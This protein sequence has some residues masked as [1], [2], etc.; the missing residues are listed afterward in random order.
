MTTQL[1]EKT[2]A[3]VKATAPI[4]A[5][6]GEAITRA[7]Y[8]RLFQ[9]QAIA[10]LFNNA[11][12]ASGAQQKALAGAIVAYAQ[13]ID[14]LGVLGAAVER[15]AQK[16]VAYN[17]LPQ[18]YDAV[19]TAL[20]GALVEV[21]GEAANEDILTAWGEAYWFLADILKGREAAIREAAAVSDGGWVGW[22]LFVV[23]KK[24]R[25]SEVISS[26]V[27]RPRDGGPVVSHRPGQYLTFQFDTP[28]Q[29]GLKR[30]YSISSAPN[31]E[32]YTITVKRED[33][34]F[35][36]I[37]L[38]DDVFEG[39]IVE[40]TPPAGDF[41]LAAT[42]GRPVVLLS[43]GVGLTPMVAM[44]EAIAKDH[45]ELEAYFVH[46]ALNS[47]VH[48]M[49]DKVRKLAD[50]HGRTRV[51]TFY[52][53]PLPTDAVGMTHDVN[54]IIDVAWLKAN[55]PF[56]TADFYLCGPRPFMRALVTGLAAAGVS[57]DRIKYEFF[58]P[59]DEL[60]AA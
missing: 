9:D 36:S 48:A 14:N 55:T 43:G 58:G 41:H 56:D 22:R 34:G 57:P 51:A 16:H 31:G 53:E 52:S 29:M 11:N 6:H 13:N 19:A 4:L 33:D 20:L 24:I 8:A 21:L 15:I 28:T 25:E 49:G 50:K 35:G 30:N 59:T 47:R 42:P 12:Q 1:S 38:H 44:L 39:S 2:V 7:M 32:T 45:P 27:L 46:G 40:A 60:L 3:V 17:I 18:H 26:F 23:E 54:G 37:F 5:I 10:K